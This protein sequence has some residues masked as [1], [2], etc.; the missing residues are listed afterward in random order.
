MR[1]IVFILLLCS[2]SSAKHLHK[3][4]WYQEIFC[5]KMNS[6]IEYQLKD[7]TRV[8]CLMENY[9]VEVDFANKWAESIGQ[10]L[11]YGYMT[12][13]APAILLIIE[14]KYKDKKY[15]VRLKAVAEHENITIWTIEPD[16]SV[17]LYF[18]PLKITVDP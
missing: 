3:E 16:Q 5:S 2:I 9:A 4:K 10:S 13:R 17:R 6:A 8:D 7:K 15:L 14:D 1:Q 11:F 12:G 18:K